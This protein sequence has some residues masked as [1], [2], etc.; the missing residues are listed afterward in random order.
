[1]VTELL[2]KYIWLIQ[3]FI[4]AGDKGMTLK[5]LQKAWSRKFGTDYARRSFN[6]HREAIADVFG[7]GIECDRSS[8]RYFIRNSNE[9]SD[10]EAGIAWLIDTFTVNNMLSLAKE[11]LSGRVSVEDIPSGR[12]HLA[13]LMNAMQENNIVEIR[14][15]KYGDTS[16]ETRRVH[17]YG[18]KESSLR[19]YLVGWS[20]ERG[21]CRVYALDRIERMDVLPETFRM[22]SGFDI[23]T[24]F[25]TSF[26]SY[27]SQAPGQ[28]IV[29]RAFGK[30]AS[31]IR[32]LPLHHTQTVIKKDEKSTTFSIFASPNDS[33]F[34][35]FLRHGP[36]IEVL[37]PENIRSGM[38]ELV[39]EM[40]GLY[41]GR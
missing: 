34:L 26:G 29:F 33:L 30:E 15:R 20:E 14:Y 38:K 41:E 36:K 37:S 35:E 12:K 10:S 1:M 13:P 40:Y 31:Y 2:E 18:I 24:L 6:N 5:E 7:I 21:S 4:A 27:L 17:P 22:P 28:T 9:I 25:A 23:D 8:N 3:K 32:D 39:S 11:R 16:P 19:W